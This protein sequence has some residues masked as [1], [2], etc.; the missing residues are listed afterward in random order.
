[1]ATKPI[2]AADEIQHPLLRQPSQ[3]PAAKDDELVPAYNP[4]L[5]KYFKDDTLFT[6]LHR[7]A[8]LGDVRVLQE[9]LHYEK[10]KPLGADYLTKLRACDDR[11]MMPVHVAALQGHHAAVAFL[12]SC[13]ADADIAESLDIDGHTAL[14]LLMTATNKIKQDEEITTEQIIIE[15]REQQ[16]WS[17]HKTIEITRLEHVLAAKYFS[18][19]HFWFLFLP[20]AL[21]TA[22]SAILSFLASSVV[23]EGHASADLFSLVVGALASVSVLIQAIS[24]QLQFRSRAAMHE[25]AALDLKG[26]V[27]DLEFQS[28]K[29]IEYG[30]SSKLLEGKKIIEVDVYQEKFQQVMQACKSHVPQ[31][32]EQCFNTL[33]DRLEESLRGAENLQDYVDGDDKIVEDIRDA[34]LDVYILA[35]HEAQNV[36]TSQRF[37]PITVNVRAA[38]KVAMETAREKL[39]EGVPTKVLPKIEEGR[40]HASLGEL[41]VVR[42]AYFKGYL[43]TKSGKLKETK[44]A[45]E[46]SSL[47]PPPGKPLPWKPPSARGASSKNLVGQSSGARG[48]TNAGAAS[49]T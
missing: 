27:Q 43:Q 5:K 16:L 38:V 6:A 12:L 21:V 14:D 3:V 35:A 22:F 10:G 19:R 32:I 46:G 9:V 25:S 42:I 47:E 40:G 36:L 31:A 15:G 11:E 2:P 41:L 26:M 30:G 28:I 4:I 17:L 49:S 44:E 7:A 1:M 39:K 34:M 13:G 37:W 29:A 33:D 8:W 20:A 48:T 18:F 23:V 24:E 45:D